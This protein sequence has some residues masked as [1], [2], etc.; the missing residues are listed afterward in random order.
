MALLAGGLILL[1]FVLLRRAVRRRRERDFVPLLVAPVRL[2][3]CASLTL[4]VLFGG[5]YVRS[6][7][8]D[9]RRILVALALLI[10]VMIVIAGGRNRISLALIYCVPV[11]QC[12]FLITLISGSPLRATF[13][14]IGHAPTP[15]RR[16]DGNLELVRTIAPSV[17]AGSK[18]AVYTLALFQPWSR[19]YEPAALKLASV[20]VGY[21]YDIG[22]LWD[23]GDYNETLTRLRALGYQ[24]LLLDSF[25]TVPATATHMPYVQF[26]TE[27]LR[28]FQTGV[29]NPP[30]LRMIS[31]FSLGDRQH[32]LF[33]IVPAAPIF[34][35]E[36]LAASL[37]GAKPFANEEQKGFPVANLNDG[38]EAPWG[39][40][41]GRSDVYAAVVL[42]A[43]HII[44]HVRIKLFCPGGRQHLRDVR[45]VTAEGGSATPAKWQFVRARLEGE[46]AFRQML[47]IPPMADM[48]EVVIEVD[49]KTM[50][51]ARTT[52]GIACL[53]SQGDLPNYLQA[54]TGVYVREIGVD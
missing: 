34:G 18:I 52:W 27:L 31:R 47:T 32:T 48:S 15:L 42:P 23:T 44:H 2:L 51:G 14:R 24:F 5:L 3:L 43:P 1:L 46:K 13:S 35:A 28:R 10:V 50:Y 4:L 19:V 9:P 40:L 37:N 6:G 20:Q 54:G 8:G 38:T 7:T 33:R 53:R 26:A 22:Y 12:A 39:S 25:P 17:P 49:P 16:T 21:G 36:G 41:E 45:I 11:I 30:G 29:A